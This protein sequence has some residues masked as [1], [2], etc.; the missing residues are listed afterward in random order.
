MELLEKTAPEVHSEFV[1]GNCVVKRTNR[2][3]NQ[4]PADQAT[5]WMNRMCKMQNGIIG[6][7]RNDQARDTFC[8]T[9]SERS[10]IS[11]DTRSF[12]NQEDNDDEATFTRHDSL[13]SRMKRDVDEVKKLI[14]QLTRFD[15]FKART[16]LVIGEDG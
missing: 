16:T 6:I 11:Q 10:R 8:V 1:S 7:T 15:V 9:W 2:L 14:K 3:F 5:E 12:L 13:P 4:V